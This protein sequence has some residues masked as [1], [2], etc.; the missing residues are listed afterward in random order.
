VGL[1]FDTQRSDAPV[2]GRA[3]GGRLDVA[4]HARAEREATGELFRHRI[5]DHETRWTAQPPARVLDAFG[6]DLRVHIVIEFQG[7]CLAF[8]LMEAVEQIVQIINVKRLYMKDFA[9]IRR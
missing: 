9:V 7:A 2:G 8:R 1:A 6:A 5:A 4:K 3:V